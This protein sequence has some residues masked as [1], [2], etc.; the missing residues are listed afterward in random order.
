[1]LNRFYC[2]IFFSLL[3]TCASFAQ[4]PKPVVPGVGL[5]DWGAFN[6]LEAQLK[7]TNAEPQVVIEQYQKLYESRPKMQA[8]IAIKLTVYVSD[9]HKKLGNNDKILEIDDWGI[10]Q[11]NDAPEVVWL[12]EHK[13]GALNAQKKYEETTKLI[14]E[15]WFSIVRGGQSG[16]DW[17]VMY[18][19]TAVRHAVDAY[20]ALAQP[21]KEIPL[22]L[23]A[24]NYIPALW[25][26]TEQGQGDWRDGW[27]YNVLIPQLIKEKRTD[28]ALSW[29]KFHYV[30]ASFDK[31]ALAR[32]TTSLGRVWGEKEEYPKIRVFSQLQEPMPDAALKNPLIGVKLPTL[33]DKIWR[34]NLARTSINLDVTQRSVDRSKAKESI[35]VLMVKSDFAGAMKIAQR[36]FKDAPDK[37]DGA[38]Q[39]C[40]VF[41]GADLSVRRANIFLSYLEGQAVDPIPAFMKEQEARQE[42]KTVAP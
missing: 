22:L 3:L 23:K 39:I 40:R 5:D 36:L 25:D 11:Y 18:A 26:D 30:T 6:Q 21:D 28:E 9:A 33:D 34:E 15:N 37:P 2:A 4:P 1:M 10:K 41:K 13:A 24:I 31:D 19:A 12:L 42:A 35:A 32:A 29:A 17:L 20:E 38:L 8:L 14:E 7:E 27:I 16:E